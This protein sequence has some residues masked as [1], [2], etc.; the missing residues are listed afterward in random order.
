MLTFAEYYEMIGEA[1]TPTFRQ[2][3]MSLY[4]D[5]TLIKDYESFTRGN[6]P[7]FNNVDYE[8]AS[9]TFRKYFTGLDKSDPTSAFEPSSKWHKGIA[10]ILG[11]KIKPVESFHNGKKIFQYKDA[12]MKNGMKVTYTSVVTLNNSTPYATD[13]FEFTGKKVPTGD[14]EFTTFPEYKPGTIVY[15]SFGYDMTIVEFY[16]IVKRSGTTVYL[17]RLKNDYITGGG[18]T[19]KVTTKKDDFDNGDKE[20]YRCRIPNG[21][22]D[23]HY[24]HLWN[25]RPV[26][27]NSMD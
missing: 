10:A 26:Y 5:L 2:Y 1:K 9:F 14:T 19:G 3:I 12:E 20:I 23:G 22:I 25:G 18:I 16:Q 17:K 8:T 13:T 6:K 27:Y 7:K 4:N 21:K 24:I 15:T 11:I